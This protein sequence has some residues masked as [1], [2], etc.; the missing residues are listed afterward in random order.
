MSMDGPDPAGTGA[1]MRPTT[2]RSYAM[3]AGF[4]EVEVLSVDDAQWRFYLLIP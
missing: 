1:V 2:M 4:R 3:E